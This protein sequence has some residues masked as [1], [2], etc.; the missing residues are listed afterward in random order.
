M[1]YATVDEL[2]A[3][4]RVAVTPSNTAALQSCLDAAA[5][6]IDASI[7]LRDPAA[8]IAPAKLPLVNRVNIL[9][10]VEWW[11]SNDAAWNVLADQS[12]GMRL[13][14]DTFARHAA[15]LR[16]PVKELFGIG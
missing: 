8:G 9:R 2:A 12:G 7:D 1:A 16:R 13:P 3:Q 6:E 11:K 4:L 15:T 14:K 10:G 5:V